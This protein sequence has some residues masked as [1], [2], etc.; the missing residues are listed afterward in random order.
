MKGL[1]KT[2]NDKHDYLYAKDNFPEDYWRP[3][4]QHLLDSRF[5]WYFV[6]NLSRADSGITD[7]THKVVENHSTGEQEETT[8]AQYELRENPNAKIFRIGFTVAEVEEIL[9]A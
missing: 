2:L 8:Y 5:C 7:D 6:E 4:F 3:E 9:S 1:P